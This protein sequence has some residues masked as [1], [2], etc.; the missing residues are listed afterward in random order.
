VSEPASY[1]AVLARRTPFLAAAWFVGRTFFVATTLA[2]L[3]YSLF[4]WFDR[5]EASAPRKRAISAWLKGQPYQQLE[6]KSA[7]IGAFDRLYGFPLMS[8]TGFFRASFVSLIIYVGFQCVRLLTSEELR[9]LFVNQAAS[10]PAQLVLSYF[11]YFTIFIASDYISL[12]IVRHRLVIGFRK[13]FI[14]LCRN[15]ILGT[16]IVIGSCVVVWLVTYGVDVIYKTSDYHDMAI[17]QFL[18]HELIL[19]FY[20]P[21]YFS[22]VMPAFLAH[23]WILLLVVG[24]VG[25]RLIFWFFCA[26]AGVQWLIRRGDERPI[27]AIGMVAA[28]LVFAVALAWQLL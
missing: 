25:V 3:T 19:I 4:D 14:S 2:Y 24:A 21:E 6:L 13:P 5:K 23:V 10:T 22:G 27:T 8:I 9:N 11:S 7:V 16:A 1:L 12:L 26:V 15:F 28:V 18:G 17:P 20:H